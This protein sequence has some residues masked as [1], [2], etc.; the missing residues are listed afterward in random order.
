MP[1]EAALGFQIGPKSVITYPSGGQQ[2]PGRGFYEISGLAW[3]GGG[4]IRTVEVSTDGGRKWNPAEIKGT[5]QRMAHMPVRLISGI[6]METRPRFFRAAPT[7]SGRQQPTRE[8]VAQYWNVPFDRN[9]R[10]PGLDNSVMPWKIAKDG[11][12]TNGLA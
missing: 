3:S 8:Q 1:K 7:R 4:A 6:G 5:P 2:L 11:S 12:V 9:Y 10:V